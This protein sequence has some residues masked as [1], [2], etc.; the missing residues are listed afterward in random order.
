M[1]HKRK[2]E[3]EEIEGFQYRVQGWFAAIM[4]LAVLITIFL[5]Q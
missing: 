5:L 3:D 1:F 4:G 2:N